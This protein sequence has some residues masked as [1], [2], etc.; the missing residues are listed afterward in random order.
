MRCTRYNTAYYTAPSF[1]MLTRRAVCGALVERISHDAA[2]AVSNGS[3]R[4]AA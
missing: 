4:M 2:R 1:H 3:P